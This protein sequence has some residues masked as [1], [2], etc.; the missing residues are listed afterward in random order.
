M[1]ETLLCCSIL[2]DF[3]IEENH[4]KSIDKT[5]HTDNSIS[6]NFFNAIVDLFAEMIYIDKL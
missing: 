1:K 4:H 3:L 5:A 6:S 2:R